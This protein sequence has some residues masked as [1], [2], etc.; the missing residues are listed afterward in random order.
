MGCDGGT[1]PKR[2]E[3]VRTKKK[4]EEKDK[5]S[6][7]AFKWQYCTLSHQI[8]KDP[9]VACEL[10]KLYNKDVIIEYL[11]DKQAQDKPAKVS[12]IKSLKDVHVLTLCKNPAWSGIAEKGDGYIDTHKSQYICPIAGIE[13]NG[14]YRFC[15]LCK[16]NCVL[17]ER[18][19]KEMRGNL[20][21][22][23]SKEYSKENDVILLN[24]SETEVE[25]LRVKMEQRKAD[26]KAA[27]HKSK[28]LKHLTA[29][30]QK[31][32]SKSETKKNGTE[33][34]PSTSGVGSGKK[35][36]ICP[37]AALCKEQNTNLMRKRFFK[38]TL[39][40]LCLRLIPLPKGLKIRMVIG[41]HTI[42]IIMRVDFILCFLK[43]LFIHT[44]WSFSLLGCLCYPVFLMLI[45][46][47]SKLVQ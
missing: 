21:P 17:S 30:A 37:P 32:V 28:K 10:G 23:C 44:M 7:L 13:M 35:P 43:L 34:G 41:L 19:L 3:L 26:A 27:K 38:L 45:L 24:G 4:A 12:H 9:I 33:N 46:D 6:E 40:N 31:E 8:L 20:C 42:H 18:A 47:R 14:K 25:S 5:D 39:S 22:S 1:I 15:Y 36:K 16:C 11:L 29:A 2:H